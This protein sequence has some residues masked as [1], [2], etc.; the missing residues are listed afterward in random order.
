MLAFLS[1]N[2]LERDAH[3]QGL[4]L[5]RSMPPSDLDQGADVISNSR[6]TIYQAK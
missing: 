1:S 5:G 3:K 6:D 4:Y 2:L